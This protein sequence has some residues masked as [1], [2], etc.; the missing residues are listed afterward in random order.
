MEEKVT[1]L[2][3]EGNANIGLFLVV[4]DSFALCG[5]ELGKTEQK[6]LEDLFNVPIY[7][8]TCLGT[9]LCGIFIAGNNTT[10]ISPPLFDHE[11]HTLQNIAKKH[12]FTLHALKHNINTFGNTIFLGTNFISTTEQYETSF[13]NKL[14]QKTEL[15]IFPV[16]E[17][18][19]ECVGA[20]FREINSKCIAS[21]DI[22]SFSDK[23]KT[24]ITALGSV[25][26]GSPYIASGV[27]GNKNGL[28]IGSASSTI[29]IQNLVENFG[30]L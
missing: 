25:N 1:L 15:P 10:L 13:L 11:M 20:L 16:K 29:E 17:Q 14:K 18:A 5:R 28:A 26:S 24:K 8:L 7:H 2:E 19:F 27:V 12:N 4:N 30:F 9:E 6:N 21:Q 22:N 23:L 3:F